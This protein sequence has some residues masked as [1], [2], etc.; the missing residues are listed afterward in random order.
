MHFETQPVFTK[1]SVK[2]L[3]MCAQYAACCSCA[4]HT[5]LEENACEVAPELTFPTDGVCSAACATHRPR[6]HT[7]LA[8][9][10]CSP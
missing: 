5:R 4:E 9:A 8:Q 1:P 2:V 10:P 6:R 3:A 7:R